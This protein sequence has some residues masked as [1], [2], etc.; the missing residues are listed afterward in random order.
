MINTVYSATSPA[1]QLVTMNVKFYVQMV[2]EKYKKKAAKC[3]MSEQ[4]ALHWRTP[5]V[6]AASI[7][8]LQKLFKD[9]QRHFLNFLDCFKSLTF[10]FV[11]S[12]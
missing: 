10:Y 8:F 6:D 4:L 5:S 9:L 11:K 12:I 3:V 2:Q 7:A 1:L